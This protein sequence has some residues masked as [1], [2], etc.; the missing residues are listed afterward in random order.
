MT[1]RAN[2]RLPLASCTVGGKSRRRR[3]LQIRMA[4]F[5][6]IVTATM[7][8]MPC[9]G[10]QAAYPVAAAAAPIVTALTVTADTLTATL[11]ML[12]TVRLSDDGDD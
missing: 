3:Q 4:M 1:V 9:W 7:L 6:A 2:P 11:T 10:C 8:L 5:V 12:K